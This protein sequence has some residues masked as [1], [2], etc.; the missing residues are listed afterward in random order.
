MMMKCPGDDFFT[1][2]TLSS[3]ENCGIGGGNLLGLSEECSNAFAREHNLEA[4]ILTLV[5]LDT[6]NK[7]DGEL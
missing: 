2:A 3:D 5:A 6:H 4:Q 1:G 7:W